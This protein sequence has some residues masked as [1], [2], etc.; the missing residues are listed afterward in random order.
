MQVTLDGQVPL[1]SHLAEL[2]ARVEGRGR[3]VRL[4]GGAAMLLWGRHLG[5]PRDMTQD[6][7]CALLAED[8]PDTDSADRLARELLEDLRDIGFERPEGWRSSRKGRF[9]YPHG[10]DE[11]TVE[12]LCGTSSVG[13][14]SRRRPAW[15]IS[16]APGRFYAAKVPWLDHVSEWLAVDARCGRRAFQPRVPDL[17]SLT[18]LKVRAVADKTRRVDQERIP[19]NLDHE[20]LRL[21]RHGLDCLQLLDWIHEHGELD[22]LVRSSNAHDE[23][24]TTARD[25][26]RWL[27]G[28]RGLVDE[29]GLA[30]LARSI[31]PLVP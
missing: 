29:L 3:R 23:I 11:V 27:L 15:R 13:R 14:P 5:R 31:E 6:L 19:A 4:V 1:F 22:R 25:V 10:D 21:R 18:V 7:D 17:A 2:C 20:K 24:R 9:S 30:P 26:T 28:H 16:T 8:F 12:F